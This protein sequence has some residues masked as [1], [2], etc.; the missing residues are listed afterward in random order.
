MTTEDTKTSHV[1]TVTSEVEVK[2]Q[3]IR[4][5]REKKQAN[6][7]ALYLD[8]GAELY[9]SVPTTG[10]RAH[11]VALFDNHYPFLK[12]NLLKKGKRIALISVGC[13]NADPEK[14]P[15]ERMKADGYDVTYFAVDCSLAALELAREKIKHID[16]PKHFLCADFGSRRFR[17]EI[18]E[19][20]K[21]HD[22]R[23]YAF[24]SATIGNLEPDYVADVVTD[25]MQKG[26]YLWV[27]VSVRMGTTPLDDRK[28]YE[29]YRDYNEMK[30][31]RDFMFRPLE[32][33][34]IP[35][36][37]GEFITEMSTKE[38][39]NALQ[40]TFKFHATKK[41]KVTYRNQRIT[42]LPGHE[43]A[44]FN[45]ITFDPEGLIN[46]FVERDFTFVDSDVKP[47]GQFLFKYKGDEGNGKNKKK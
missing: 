6:Q 5:L 28:L 13:G 11:A 40:F 25:L 42:L 14:E 47:L 3:F 34:G 27:D 30:E 7:N 24:F 32:D 18:A 9:Y 20:T 22:I 1:K 36:D 38:E 16:I 15:L 41:V 2:E 29:R 12:K 10:S 35:A 8:E 45:I 43:I 33:L 26:D 31:W 19:L 17:D 23:V 4:M 21:D 44:L 39:L 37:S 46:F